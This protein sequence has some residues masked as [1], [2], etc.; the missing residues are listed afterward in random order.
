[1]A[2]SFQFFWKQWK[3]ILVYRETGENIS[4]KHIPTESPTLP[5]Q[6]CE[7]LSVSLG[8]SQFQYVWVKLEPQNLELNQ[9]CGIIRRNNVLL[10]T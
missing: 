5:L 1:M 7:T 4:N 8:C 2:N 6:I 9:L 3:S 10:Q